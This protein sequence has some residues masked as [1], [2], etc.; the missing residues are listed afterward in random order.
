MRHSIWHGCLKPSEDFDEIV[1]C[2]MES[3]DNTLR[4][5]R[6]IWMQD[7]V[8]SHEETIKSVNQQ[9]KLPLMLLLINGSLW[10]TLMSWFLAVKG[11]SIWFDELMKMLPQGYYV[12]SKSKFMGRFM[13]C[14]YPDYQLRLFYKRRYCLASYYSCRPY[15]SRQNR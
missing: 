1:I 7:R 13:H 12:P 10:W 11:L 8:L 5:R 2:D 6:A 14:F 9:G 4:N 3:T 15:H